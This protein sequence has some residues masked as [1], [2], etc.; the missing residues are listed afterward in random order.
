LHF[1][2]P[3]AYAADVFS[4]HIKA[5]MRIK[6][7][8]SFMIAVSF[9]HSTRTGIFRHCRKPRRQAAGR[10]Y[11]TIAGDRQG[12]LMAIIALPAP[13]MFASKMR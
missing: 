4:A 12:Q 3:N 11:A 7:G 9:R 6:T 5:E 8:I 10:A 1:A 13:N 2:S